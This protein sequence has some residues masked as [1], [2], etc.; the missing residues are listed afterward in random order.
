MAISARN[1][2]SGRLFTPPKMNRHQTN[3]LPSC[4]GT[5]QLFIVVQ[6]EKTLL[7]QIQHLQQLLARWT[8]RRSPRAEPPHLP[9]SLWTS[10]P[11][12]WT[13]PP[14]VGGRLGLLL[15]EL[16]GLET[17]LDSDSSAPERDPQTPQD[18]PTR[19]REASL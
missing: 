10:P 14:A 2:H 11:S 5:Y 6:A 12:L 8:P 9:L 19:S 7:F 16:E 18:A 4:D 17:R 15:G 13:F 3:Q 1:D